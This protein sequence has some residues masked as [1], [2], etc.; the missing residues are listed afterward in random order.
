MCV[1]MFVCV[2]LDHFDTRNVKNTIFILNAVTKLKV[3]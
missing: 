3:L 1:Y 2:Y